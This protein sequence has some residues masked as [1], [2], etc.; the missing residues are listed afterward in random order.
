[1]KPSKIKITLSSFNKSKVKRKIIDVNTFEIYKSI[2]DCAKKRQNFPSAIYQQAEI[3]DK[4][5]WLNDWE[6]LPE[7]EKSKGNIYFWNIW[8]KIYEEPTY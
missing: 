5:L 4:I 6:L 2:T 3:G 8:E 1:M 7:K